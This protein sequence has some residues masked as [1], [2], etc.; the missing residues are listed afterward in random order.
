MVC[1][2][3]LVYKFSW[4]RGLCFVC[5]SILSPRSVPST[6]MFWVSEWGNGWMNSKPSAIRTQSALPAPSLTT[7]PY[8]LGVLGTWNPPVFPESL[9]CFSVPLPQNILPLS[10]YSLISSYWNSSYPSRTTLSFF[11]FWSLS[12]L[13]THHDLP[14]AKPTAPSS[15]LV[16]QGSLS[17]SDSSYVVFPFL[18]DGK[19]HKGKMVSGSPLVPLKHWYKMSHILDCKETWLSWVECVIS[20]ALSP[21]TVT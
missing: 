2:L 19:P 20:L 11:S 5:C 12:G 9:L 4:K 16:T 6:W 21:E 18:L 15:S 7:F 1:L 13:F 3:S 10:C 14:P 8:L 17:S